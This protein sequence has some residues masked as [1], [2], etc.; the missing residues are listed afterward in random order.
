MTDLQTYP[1]AETSTLPLADLL[2]KATTKHHRL[3][4]RSGIVQQMLK[5]EIRQDAYL[6]Y[7]R[8]LR[9]IYSVL[10]QELRKTTPSSKRIEPFLNPMLH[11]KKP[12][13]SDLNII[14][15]Y[16]EWKR[17][18]ILPSCEAYCDDIQNTRMSAP[19][20]LLGHI[21]VRYLGDM[22]GGQVLE[23]LLRKTLDLPTNAYSFYRYP[24]IVDL[25]T[26]RNDYRQMFNKTGFN[27]AEQTDI[28]K[29][30]IRGFEFNILLSKA[31]EALIQ[32][33]L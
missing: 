12:L 33:D 28:I 5:G 25:S 29:A 1:T 19:H 17:L 15:G 10:E 32:K 31:V 13:T 8:N 24:A 27:Q 2:K 16:K 23:R 6:L 18:P 14:G 20:A 11:R 22:N 3:A 21:Y 7:L 26:F 9:A 30:A 4:E